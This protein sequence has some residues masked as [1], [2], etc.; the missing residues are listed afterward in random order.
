MKRRRHSHLSVD[1]NPND[2]ILSKSNLNVSARGVLY[3]NAKSRSQ[4][5][6]LA[7]MSSGQSSD[8]VPLGKRRTSGLGMISHLSG[9]VASGRAGGGDEADGIEKVR[10]LIDSGRTSAE[11]VLKLYRQSSSQGL[12]VVS[13]PS[14][15]SGVS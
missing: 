8:A 2:L 14:M 12:S 13:S 6:R 9:N 11:K 15:T 4:R 5:H 3:E 10:Q 1:N 7:L